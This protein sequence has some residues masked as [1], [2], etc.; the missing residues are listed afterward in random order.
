MLEKKFP[1]ISKK[2][3]KKKKQQNLSM[4]K[5]H[6]YRTENELIFMLLRSVIKTIFEKRKNIFLFRVIL[7]L[8]L[9]WDITKQRKRKISNFFKKNYFQGKTHL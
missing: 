4:K 8:V 6:F 9:L 1:E 2:V 3:V 5:I 7:L